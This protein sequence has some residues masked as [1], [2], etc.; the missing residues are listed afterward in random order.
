[1]AQ[2]LTLRETF[3]EARIFFGRFPGDH[4]TFVS[5]KENF[6]RKQKKMKKDAQERLMKDV[7]GTGKYNATPPSDYCPP[8]EKFRFVLEDYQCLGLYEMFPKLF[9]ASVIFPY[10][11]EN[12]TSVCP[13]KVGARRQVS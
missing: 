5:W 9:C 11:K 1:M 3:E 7:G 4:K 10:Q 12:L 8:V 6:L 2:N 13:W